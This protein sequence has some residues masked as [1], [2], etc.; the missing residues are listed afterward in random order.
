MSAAKFL[1][2]LTQAVRRC[3]HC[4]LNFG[5]DFDG[6]LSFSNL[7]S[8]ASGFSSAMAQTLLRDYSLMLHVMILEDKLRSMKNC[9]VLAYLRRS[10]TSSWSSLRKSECA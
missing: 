8:S 7:I 6:S 2:D 4:L 9:M 3:N 1:F 10:S 5:V